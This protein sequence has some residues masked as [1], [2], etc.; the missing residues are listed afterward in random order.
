MLCSPFSTNDAY[1]YDNELTD[2]MFLTDLYV[3]GGEQ[4]KNLRKNIIE[5]IRY[6]RKKSVYFVGNK[7]CGK[8]T[9]IH[10]IIQL[11]DEEPDLR[12]LCLDFGDSSATLTIKKAK[13]KLIQKI[14]I[15]LREAVKKNELELLHSFVRTYEKNEYEFDVFWDYNKGLDNFYE[16]LKEIINATSQD[17][18]RQMKLLIRQK[19]ADLELFQLF[20]L[21]ILFDIEWQQFHSQNNE[22]AR[23]KSTAIIFDNLDNVVVLV[24]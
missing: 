2:E 18:S 1:N 9:F 16:T 14:Y 15:M 3:E 21:M 17:L 12:S 19:M 8:T 13:E 24:T 5:N 10:K 6:S 11:I 4:E 22:K 20:L 7:G 23:H